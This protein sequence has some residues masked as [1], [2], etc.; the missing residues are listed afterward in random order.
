M[1]QSFGQYVGNLFQTSPKMTI[2]SV[3]ETLRLMLQGGICPRKKQCNRW[4][5]TQIF[6]RNGSRGQVRKPQV[7]V[8]DILFSSILVILCALWFQHR[9][10]FGQIDGLIDKNTKKRRHG[11]KAHLSSIGHQEGRGFCSK[12]RARL[13]YHDRLWMCLC[14]YVFPQKIL[15]CFNHPNWFGSR[16]ED[17]AGI[18]RFPSWLWLVNPPNISTRPEIRPYQ[19]LIN[20]W[21]P[22]TRPKLRPLFLGRARKRGVGWLA[23][24]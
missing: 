5:T 22:L 7:T 19:V 23:I 14:L 3:H 12:T 6:L 8:H 10:P 20:H 1:T 4:L 2:L 13:V 24:I 15:Q 18:N 9:Y 21:F 11:L 16:P 17:E